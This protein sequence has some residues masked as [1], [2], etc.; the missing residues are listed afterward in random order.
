MARLSS[1][2]LMV[3]L[4]CGACGSSEDFDVVIAGGRVVDPETGLDATLHLGIRGDTIVRLSEEPLMGARIIDAAGLV[5]A[6]GF[7]DLHQHDQTDEGYRLKALDGVTA[8]LDLEGGV[9][10]IERF[11]AV[12][13]GQS[14]I[15]FGATASQ[16]AA[17]T[18]A[19]DAS[20]LPSQFGPE[21][22]VPPPTGAAAG[23]P[24]TPE[25]LERLL[26]RLSSEV[27]AGALGVGMGIEYSPGATREEIRAVFD[28]AAQ[29]AVPVFVHAR[30]SGS[31]GVQSVTE[32]VTASEST[33]AALH[34][35][36]INSTCRSSAPECLSV[37]SSAR[38]RGLDVTTE[39]YPYTAGMTFLNSA[40]F[41]PGWREAQD[42]DYGDVELPE[43]GE[44]LTRER[45][46]ALRAQGEARLVLVHMNPE[47]VVEAVLANPLVAIASDGMNAHPRGAGTYSRVLARYVRE[48]GAIGLSDAIRKM[49]L[50]PAQR[51]ETVMPLARRLGRIQEGAQAD[52]VLFDAEGI[53]D[54]ATFSAPREPSVG[55]AYLLVRGTVVVDQGRLVTVAAPGRAFVRGL[56]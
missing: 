25:Q 47:E 36:H 21:A 9:P 12:R 14:P 2:A 40:V 34:I 16:L 49:S 17:R 11:I 32:V 33:R 7:I 24:S 8:A 18:S 48:R 20:L 39:A 56:E 13:Q 31:A 10:D 6:P 4:T 46:D 23:A 15:H 55:V 29:L 50:L 54:Q 43:T 35:V 22:G 27:K 30:Q 51:L 38:E 26:A 41:D 45:F 28:L 37:I 53:Q 5:V 19:F 1:V 44:R 52:I 42:L 3:V